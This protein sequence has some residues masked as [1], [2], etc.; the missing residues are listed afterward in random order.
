M[1]FEDCDCWDGYYLNDFGRCKGCSKGYRGNSHNHCVHCPDKNERWCLGAHTCIC[2][3]NFSRRQGICVP[4][5]ANEE[6]DGH[7]ACTCIDN[8]SRNNDGLCEQCNDNET[9]D[10]VT[11]KCKCDIGYV[12]NSLGKCE[13]CSLATHKLV[14]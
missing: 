5:E 13:Y 10:P 2:L 1:T 12:R 7:S 4:C 9:R 6:S 3:E 8:Y 11:K 14:S